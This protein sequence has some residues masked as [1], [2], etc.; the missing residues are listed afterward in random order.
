ME[1]GSLVK[2]AC[3]HS[4]DR[5][6]MFRVMVGEVDGITPLSGSDCLSDID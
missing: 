5:Y 3:V 6:Y 4:G 1:P 2:E